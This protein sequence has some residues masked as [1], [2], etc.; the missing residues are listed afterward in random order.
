MNARDLRTR[1]AVL[2]VA[3]FAGVALAQAPAPRPTAQTPATGPGDNPV[4]TGQPEPPP[5]ILTPQQRGDPEVFPPGVF[6]PTRREPPKPVSEPPP[7]GVK[8]LPI[9]MFTSKN[10]YKDQASWLDPRYYR[11]NTPRQMVEA[12]WERGR[13]GANPPTTAS[14]G[15]CKIDYPRERMVSPY[16][17]KTAK[18][19]Y[20]ALM[21]KA[22]EHGGPTVY[23]K[24]TTPDWDGFYIRDPVATDSPGFVGPD[25]MMGG[26]GRGERWQWGGIEQAS[27]VLSLL[28]PEYQK[29]YVQMLYHETVSNSKQW[30]AS[31]CLPEGFIRWW[32]NA[33]RGA[34][35]ELTIT[36][37]RVEFLSGIAA[38]FLREVLIGRQHVQKVPQWY[39]ETVG[40]WDGDTLISWTAN[41]QGWTQHTMFEFSNKMESVETYKPLYDANHNFIG[42]D[43][44]AVWYDPEAYVQPLRVRDRFLRRAPA[45]DPT[46][47]YTFIECLSNIKNVKGR[48]EQLSKSDPNFIDYYGRPWAQNWEKWFE[49]GWDKPA[50]AGAPKDVLDLFK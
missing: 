20:E 16:P 23:T 50:D 45:G 25:R 32:A 33:S 24:A 28:T 5:S 34:N 30:N 38:N 48:P 1:S 8:P 7:P 19:H 42:I 26:L 4:L 11:C 9:D 13:M 44:E 6:F 22:K 47:R 15:N 21:A 49:Q 29:R 37:T 43:H 39:G 35:F 12:M 2:L 14:W 3:A 40:F 10:F 41:V 36:P 18:E 17:Y 46:A 27:T 31:F